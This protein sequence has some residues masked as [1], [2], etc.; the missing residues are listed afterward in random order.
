MTTSRPSSRHRRAPLVAEVVAL[1]LLTAA[2]QAITLLHP[3]PPSDGLL[4]VPLSGITP[5]IGIG[6]AAVAVLRRRF[7]RVE[8]LTVVVAAASLLVSGASGLAA[9]AGTPVQ[10]QS[11][12]TEALAL[13][14]LCGAVCHLRPVRS[15]AP[16]VV[17]VGV[18]TTV[19][20]PLRFGFDSSWALLAVPAALLWGGSVATGLIMRDSD[21]RYD[22]Q[23]AKARESER[24]ALARELHDFVAHHVTGIVVLAQ[25]ARVAAARREEDTGVYT[26]MERAGGEALSAM[27]RL[28]GMLR[29]EDAGD[30]P[31][32]EPSLLAELTLLTELEEACGNDPRVEL[33][34]PAELGQLSLPRALVVAAQ[35][36]VLE[37]VTNARRYAVPGTPITVSARL[38]RK[39]FTAA[40]ELEVG[41]DA[42]A[43]AAR[44]DGY[45]LMGMAERA[46]AVGGTLSSGPTNGRWRVHA[47]LPVDPAPEQLFR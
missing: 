24:L 6:A 43:D 38:R 13:A 32:T 44:S 23:L 2:D 31:G 3:L 41:N 45:G 46:Q 20:A 25:G 17:L 22:A 5:A 30:P 36:I 34:A 35:R 27:R 39:G 9:L 12:L 1:A 40:L 28:V 11:A 4:A 16:L 18:A 10:A 7:G 29:T 33:T 47:T 42:A 8:L 26:E 14:L 37:A 21:S 15:V 19:A